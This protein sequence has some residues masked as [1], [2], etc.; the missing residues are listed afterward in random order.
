MK[1]GIRMAARMTRR[2]FVCWAAAVA[3]VAGLLTP[4]AAGAAPVGFSF[5]TGNFQWYVGQ[6]YLNGSLVS[7]WSPTGGNPDGYVP[8]TDSA[9]E[10]GCPGLPCNFVTFAYCPGPVCGFPGGGLPGK[11][12]GTFSL[13]FNSSV[14]PVHPLGVEILTLS[15]DAPEALVTD[16]SVPGTG[17]Q[18]VSVPLTESGWDYCADTCTPATAL[19]MKCVLA[20]ADDMNLIADLD[21]PSGTGETYGIDN[22]L[23][24]DGPATT[25]PDCS[26]AAVPAPQPAAGQTGQPAK[27]TKCKKKKKKK[28]K[29]SAESAKKKCKKKKMK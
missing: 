8:A 4:A 25:P 12:G 29:R 7:D 6:D 10:T 28:K 14:T 1:P 24:T 22:V 21:S 16:L 2:R 19:Q 23:F 27:K 18:H 3:V 5:D 13:D 15:I 17:W 20:K 11:Y 26:P 9:S